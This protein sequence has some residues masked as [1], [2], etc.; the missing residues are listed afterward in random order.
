VNAKRQ[1]RVEWVGCEHI[2]DALRE[3]A[4][5]EIQCLGRD[6]AQMRAMRVERKAGERRDDCRVSC[7][8]LA[9]RRSIHVERASLGEALEAFES[10]LRMCCKQ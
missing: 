2:P 5:G 7:R 9:H 3:C 1:V 8:C 4:E 6:C 10:V